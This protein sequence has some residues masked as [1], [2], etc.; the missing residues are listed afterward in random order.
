ML[1]RGFR[2][3]RILVTAHR[4]P[5]PPYALGPL[6][7][8]A[9]ATAMCDVSDGLVADLGH[10]AAAS[11]VVLDL[12]GDVFVV[13]APLQDA[14]AALGVDPMSWILAGGD[15]HALAATF[16]PDSTL[17]EGFVVVGQVVRSDGRSAEP[18]GVLVD[19][20]PWSGAGGHDHFA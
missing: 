9:G 15:D 10:V 7:A 18:A 19:G 12:R 20:Q 5:E 13:A 3:P 16:P 14:A 6:A 4:R 11:G 17:P 8:L 2:M 1:Q